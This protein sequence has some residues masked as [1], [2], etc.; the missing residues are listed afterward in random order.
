MEVIALDIG[1]SFIKAALIGLDPLTVHR[2]ER[3]PFPA[4]VTGLPAP[5]RETD[6]EA[7]MVVVEEA[8]AAAAGAARDCAGVV[9]CGQMHGVVLLD[10]RGAPLS[11]FI[12]WLDQRV[13]EA[14]FAEF[15]AQVSGAGRAELG[16]ELR[17]GIALPLLWWLRRHGALPAQP[18]TPVSIADFV[19]ARLCGAAPVMEPTQAA[20]FGAYRLARGEWHR[21]LIG[22]LGLDTLRWPDVRPSGAIVGMWQGTPCYA[23]SGDQQCAL[24]GALLGEGELSINIGTGSQVAVIA[25]SLVPGEFQTRPYFDGRFLQTITHIP[26]GRALSA[27]VGL[28]TSLGGTTEEA[29][30][31]QIDAAV[32]AVPESDLRAHIAF[33]PGPCGD[34]GS[35]ENLREGNL[36]VGHLFRAVFESMGRNY[37]ACARRLHP[38]RPLRRVVFSGGVARRNGLVRELSAAALGLPHRLSPDPEDTLYGLGVLALA[39]TGRQPDVRAATRAAA[40]SRK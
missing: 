22:R 34:S 18:A 5:Y 20:A 30:W 8:L 35:F 2:V 3:R 28:L 17:P 10:E 38:E 9:L 24:A 36:E 15:A 29:A 7:V 21:E 31:R 23:A 6:P 14:E 11:N 16:N 27:L 32:A 19:A 4:F 33:Y 40:S 39:F 1:T 25:E 26:G 13:T 12:C 37:A